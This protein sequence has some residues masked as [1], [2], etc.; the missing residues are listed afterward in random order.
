MGGT[1]Q[2]RQFAERVA[3]RPD[4]TVTLSLA[5][6][7]A[8]PARQPVPVRVGGFG[9]VGDQLNGYY[10]GTGNPGYFSE[11]LSRYRALAPD[12]IQ[13][14]AAKFLRLDRRVELVVEPKK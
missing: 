7:T 6:R 5:G 1:T 8:A 9:G 12:D 2:A 10:I 14:M 4:L 3:K 13:A 11:D